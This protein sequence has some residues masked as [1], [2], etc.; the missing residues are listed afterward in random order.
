MSYIVYVTRK[1]ELTASCFDVNKS[2]PQWYYY[3][4]CGYRGILEH[5]GLPGTR[6]LD[7]LC[8][9]TIP[10]CAGLSSSSALVC[11]SAL[12]TMHA[13]DRQLSRVTVHYCL[14]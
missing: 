13:N 2:D 3:F 8:D 4:L 10:P 14:W 9:G 7:I 5:F 12:V 6:G 11:C 1:I